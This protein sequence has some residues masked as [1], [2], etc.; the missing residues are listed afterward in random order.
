MKN[1]MQL[2]KLKSKYAKGSKV[3][4][5]P[6]YDDFLKYSETAP[7]NRR[8]E[9]GWSYGDPTRYDHYGMWDALGKPKDFQDALKRNP[10]WKPDKL[11]GMYH[12]FSTN[13]NTGIWLKS[14]IAGQKEPGSTG[15][16]E[17]KE[18]AL[19]GDPN[20]NPK[21]LSLV[22]DP[23]I[24]RLRYMPIKKENTSDMK[25]NKYQ[26]M[27]LGG[28]LKDTAVPWVKE[29]KEGLIGYAKVGVGAALTA[30]GIAAPVGMSLMASGASDMIGEITDGNS[31]DEI[32]T[33]YKQR[34]GKAS[35]QYQTARGG[36][37]L[38]GM[39]KYNGN[40]HEQGGIP[41][42]G[43]GVEVEDGEVRTGDMIHSDSIKITKP[44]LKR[45]G[46]LLKK[47]DLNK[48]VADV[49]KSR[50]KKFEKRKGDELNDKAQAMLM[51][52]FEEMS[53]ELSQIYEMAQDMNKQMAMGGKVPK[54]KPIMLDGAEVTAMRPRTKPVASINPVSQQL[55]EFK[56]Q[57]S[58]GGW[59]YV[60][61]TDAWMNFN[62]RDQ[63][64]KPLQMQADQFEQANPN[65][66]VQANY[67]NLYKSR[68]AGGSINPKALQLLRKGTYRSKSGSNPYL[69]EPI[70]KAA[71]GADIAA[72]LSDG[73]NAPIIGSGIGMLQNALTPVEKVK[74]DQ[75]RYTPTEVNKVSSQS[76][77]NQ[78]RRGYG[79]AKA[80]LRR[81]N[82]SGL[83][84]RYGQLAAS[85]AES[86]SDYATQTDQINAQ[87]QNQ[88]SVYDSQNR[89]RVNAQNQQVS[90]AEAE[91]N[92]ANR[93]MKK[94]TGEAYFNNMTTQ[95]GQKSRDDKMMNEQSR[96]FDEM[97]KIRQGYLDLSKRPDSGI[98]PDYDPFNSS[99]NFGFE[100][101]DEQINDMY[102]SG[103]PEALQLELQR[104]KIQTL[105]RFGGSLRKLKKY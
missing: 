30:T 43:L 54:G 98:N 91:A 39:T 83:L 5:P 92:A 50:N 87:T 84:N 18:F 3:S 35:Q 59:D 28:W 86:V 99:R 12:G 81:L 76:G 4:N 97:Q 49:V 21:K 61:D 95:I 105:N 11:D 56:S 10:D 51:M 72:F 40:K 44:M 101:D 29:N 80:D 88:A 57:I 94:S 37:N 73:G 74:Y 46:N 16:M 78:I 41:L 7:E 58:H 33:P 24:K 104:R 62:K 55:S 26:Q 75:M 71:G 38:N 9:K 31:Q 1:K 32:A 89:V 15:F 34:V 85:E 27:D 8:P 70:K 14:H 48:S 25:K 68:K 100:M 47:T 65:M 45:Y 67:R 69:Y 96:Q 90:V 77:I 23:E 63:A 79:N 93:A 66:M 42:G 102:L 52:P 19:S 36:L 2:S 17:L 60:P 22:Y 103:S 6:D 53:D 13:P 64:G 20:W 82:P